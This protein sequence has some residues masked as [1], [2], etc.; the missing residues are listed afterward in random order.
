[1]VQHL[2]TWI[3]CQTEKCL[4]DRARHIHWRKTA[5]SLYALLKNIRAPKTKPLCHRLS[6][7]YSWIIHNATLWAINLVC[8]V[9]I[10]DDMLDWNWW[11]E[12]LCFHF[13][14]IQS[15]LLFA[16]T[17]QRSEFIL[18]WLIYLSIGFIIF[19]SMLFDIFF[20]LDSFLK[21]C[22]CISN[23]FKSLNEPAETS[24]RVF[25]KHGQKTI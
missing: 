19:R 14:V 4:Q 7:D 10:H 2:H 3:Q 15:L 5:E 16:S 25:Q 22:V 9:W 17:L 13:F 8:L 12:C 18:H 23:L 21:T 20:L 1:M 6:Y 11:L 24:L